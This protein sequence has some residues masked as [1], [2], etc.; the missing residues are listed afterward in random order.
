MNTTSHYTINFKM[1]CST[2]PPSPRL[3]HC[4]LVKTNTGTNR[5]FFVQKSYESLP[6]L[7]CMK[8]LQ[9]VTLSCEQVTNSNFSCKKSYELLLFHT[10][11][12]QIIMVVFEKGYNK[13]NL[14]L[15]K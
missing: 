12:L 4:P 10:K 15:L 9:I 3:R 5:Y 14:F 1:D 11:K 2:N 8:R 7:F 13:I 6:V